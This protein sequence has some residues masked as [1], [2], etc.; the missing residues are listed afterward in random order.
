MPGLVETWI[1][2]G[3]AGFIGSNFVRLSLAERAPLVVVADKLTY[4]GSRLNLEDLDGHP[5]LRFLRL[6][7]A[8]RLSVETLFERHPPAALVHFA[9][10]SHVDRSID[11][12]EAFVRTNILGTYELLRAARRHWSAA[13]GEARE[14][15]RF[16]HV[17]TD[18]IY[19][20]AGAGER[21]DERSAHAP[22]SPYAASKAAADDLVRAWHRTY[23]L[24]AL[25][26]HSSNN[27]G[28]YQFPEKLVPLMLLNALEGRPLPLYGDG[29]QVRD[30]IFV[31][32][33]CQALLDVLERG[34]PGE[35]YHVAGGEERTNLELVELLCA[36]IEERRPARENPALAE[37]GVAR[38]RDLVTSVE[39]RPGH[40]RRYALDARKIAGELGWKPGH[41]LAT[42]LA[43]TV[44]WY[45][46][47]LDWCERLQADRYRRERLGLG[48]PALPAGKA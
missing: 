25:V 31:E 21:F 16:L 23:G 7:V 4:A 42:G 14:R 46:D 44:A 15:F 38:Y 2:T 9:A 1:V 41:D 24:P 20:S 18:E 45:L 32:D 17:S 29:R 47:H 8:D 5:R 3:G 37:R 28:P 48:S 36:E 13:S 40:D 10:E 30:W 26:T 12:P 39:D 43:R 34:R 19:G 27:Y 6:D 33:H 11:E 35:R 22:N